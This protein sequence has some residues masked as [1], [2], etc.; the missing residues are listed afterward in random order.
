MVVVVV[1]TPDKV[2]HHTISTVVR[3]LMVSRWCS[4]GGCSD[5][6]TK[7]WFNTPSTG[8]RHLVVRSRVEVIRAENKL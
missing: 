5:T 3:Y 2:W 4:G 1:L 6:W 7:T 8:V